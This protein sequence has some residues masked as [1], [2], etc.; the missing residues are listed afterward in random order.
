MSLTASP[1]RFGMACP[2][3]EIERSPYVRAL[4][5]LRAEYLILKIYHATPVAVKG[6]NERLGAKA[7]ALGLAREFDS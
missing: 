3:K 4:A 1:R 6:R 7:T 5:L 2:E